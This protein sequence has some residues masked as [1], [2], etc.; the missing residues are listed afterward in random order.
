MRQATACLGL[1]WMKTQSLAARSAVDC[2]AVVSVIF[3]IRASFPVYEFASVAIDET[4]GEPSGARTSRS[5][6]FRF[7]LGSRCIVAKQGRQVRFNYSVD[8]RNLIG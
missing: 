1:V 6:G 3:D 4:D 2:E 8:F 7:F 5:G